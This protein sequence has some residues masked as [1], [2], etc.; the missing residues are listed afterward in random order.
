M[1]LESGLEECSTVWVWVKDRN[2]IGAEYAS[3]LSTLEYGVCHIAGAD[4]K[5][6][7]VEG[8]HA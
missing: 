1:S 3:G 4:G 8:L 7:C 5:D 2:L 6:R